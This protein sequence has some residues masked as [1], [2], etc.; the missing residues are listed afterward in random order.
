VIF[1]NFRHK[2]WRFSRKSTLY[3]CTFFIHVYIHKS[4]LPYFRQSFGRKYFL[5]HHID[6]RYRHAGFRICSISW[7]PTPS[8]TP[9]PSRWPPWDCPAGTTTRSSSRFRRGR[10][11]PP[12]WG[13]RWVLRGQIRGARWLILRPKIPSWGRCYN[14]LRFS[15]NLGK[16]LAFFSKTNVMIKFF[17]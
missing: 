1:A 7:T 17:A 16:K 2:N 9:S 14:F 12:E 10:G 11:P 5:S 3:M 4:K 6:P 15:T 8:S 13:R